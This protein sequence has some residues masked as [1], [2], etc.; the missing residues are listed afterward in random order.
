MK[1]I[2]DIWNVQSTRDD[3]VNMAHI[4]VKDNI[5]KYDFSRRKWKMLD[6][7]FVIFGRNV[8]PIADGMKQHNV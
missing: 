6:L 7:T 1:Y 2:T 3:T 4:H 8:Q 5:C